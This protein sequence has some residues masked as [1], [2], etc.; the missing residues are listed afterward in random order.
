MVLIILLTALLFLPEPSAAQ[1]NGKPPDPESVLINR[2]EQ[3]IYGEEER[4]MLDEIVLEYSFQDYQKGLGMLFQILETAIMLD[5]DTLR[6]DCHRFLGWI[7]SQLGMA[8][9]SLENNLLAN[10]FYARINERGNYNW[11]LVNIGNTY[12]WEDHTEQAL[13]FYRDALGG[14][15]EMAAGAGAADHDI[16]RQRSIGIDGMAVSLNNIALCHAK[17]EDYAQAADYH[18]KALEMRSKM[19]SAALISQSYSYLG[20]VYSVMGQEARALE[21]FQNARQLLADATNKEYTDIAL[22]NNILAFTY[23][24]MGFHFGRQQNL[25]EAGKYFGQ[26]IKM[27]KETGNDKELI[28]TWLSMINFYSDTGKQEEAL[29]FAYDA[30]ELATSNEYWQDKI[31]ALKNIAFIYSAKGD[32]QNAFEYSRRVNETEAGLYRNYSDV[33]LLSIER[34][35]ANRVQFENMQVLRQ[36]NII[37]EM[38]LER[39]RTIIIF[40]IISTVLVIILLLVFLHLFNLKRKTNHQLQEMNKAMHQVNKRLIDSEANLEKINNELNR[41]NASLLKSEK[42]LKI[43]NRTKDKFF[44]ILAHDLRSPVSS[45]MQLAELLNI[46]YDKLTEEKKKKFINELQNSSRG[47]FELV[48]TLLLWSRSQQESLVLK[49]EDIVLKEVVEKSRK[50]FELMATNKNIR[51]VSSVKNN[52]TVHA[53]VNIVNTILRNLISNAVKYSH[54]GG[55][56]CIEAEAGEKVASISVVDKGVGMTPEIK[57]SIF[58]IGISESSSGTD[59]E[60]G[61]GLGLV[62][63]KELVEQQGGTISAESKEGKGSKFTFTLP[64]VSGN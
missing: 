37:N 47:L 11:T 42:N 7:Y 41:K 39:Q 44:S 60:T 10:H 26:S 13:R 40:L 17:N 52:T 18:H 3:G 50:S 2:I 38:D 33:V 24:R 28:N 12:Y 31:L 4:Q 9:R 1:D 49:Q 45:I 59:G 29:N 56:V 61:T 58:N 15:E 63:C 48:E 55:T 20:Y 30:L 34:D 32:F 64:L 54:K 62:I 23:R 46:K 21:Y 22:S 19:G 51:L 43:L 27:Y 6:Y 25:A 35:I 57:Q 8:D 36:E 53:D 16:E 14:F 5:L